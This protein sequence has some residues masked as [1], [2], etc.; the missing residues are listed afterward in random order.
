M[1]K[2]RHAWKKRTGRAV[3]LPS[4]ANIP[5]ALSRWRS[6]PKATSSQPIP[7][8]QIESKRSKH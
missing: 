4:A 6:M 8:G 1:N 5:S 3:K 7:G 2:T